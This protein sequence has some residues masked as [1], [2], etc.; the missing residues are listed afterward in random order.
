LDPFAAR[1]SVIGNLGDTW[2]S[3]IATPAAPQIQATKA[4]RNETRVFFTTQL[5]CP[6]DE[7]TTW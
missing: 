6:K 3:A 1:S 4:I 2:T 5:S 7:T